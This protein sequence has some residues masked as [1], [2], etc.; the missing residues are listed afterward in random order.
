MK[1]NIYIDA[2]YRCL[3]KFGEE[4]C[5][6]TVEIVKNKNEYII[7]VA[8]GIGSGVKANIL[9]TLTSKIISTMMK[10]DASIEDTVYTVVNT[11][12]VDVNYKV[13]YSAFSIL[14]IGYDKKAYLVE[15]DCPE[16]IFIRNGKIRPIVYNKRIISG[17][18]IKESSFDIEIGDVFILLSD[19][20]L[21]AGAGDLLN[22][23]WNWE[24]VSEFVAKIVKTENTASKLSWILS[25][26]CKDLYI[27]KPGDDTTVAAI[28]IIPEQ[29]VNIFSGPP[30]NPEDD[31]KI[32]KEFISSKG[33]KIICGGTS[34]NIFSRITGEKIITDFENADS[35]IPPIAF[36]KSVDFV[37]EGVL[38]LQKTVNILKQYIKNPVD[39][40]SFELIDGDNGAANIAKILI[41]ECTHLNLFI[42]RKINPAH[43]NN[44]LPFDLSIKTVILEELCSIV[45]KLGKIVNKK[46]Y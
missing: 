41:E 37:T 23:G 28:K 34:A 7:V 21:Y 2:A 24:N 42:G 16:C 19:G 43:Q 1:E 46:F 44:K 30:E 36:I 8:D 31:E 22:Q 13:A 15:F 20:V 4:L 17:K 26:T 5:G 27:D 32:I 6:D 25:E 38:T 29:I 12:P 3:N 10:Y 11:L 33:K 40:N 45:V 39:K 9:S 35:E 14:K 18:T